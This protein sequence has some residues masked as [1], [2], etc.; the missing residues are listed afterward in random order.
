MRRFNR[1]PAFC[2]IETGDFTN[3]VAG[4]RIGNL[5]SA[6]VLVGNPFAVD[7]GEGPKQAFVV[8][9]WRC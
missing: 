9:K 4:R 3:L 1:A 7:V 2:N 8:Q 6:A 5:E